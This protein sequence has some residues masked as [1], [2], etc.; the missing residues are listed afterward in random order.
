MSRQSELS[1]LVNNYIADHEGRQT[2]DSF[3]EVADVGEKSVDDFLK[4]L[5]IAVI[6]QEVKELKAINTALRRME[7]GEYGMCIDCNKKIAAARLDVNPAAERC[8]DCQN[9]Y[10]KEHG[11]NELNPSL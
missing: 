2:I 8:V 9:R 6:T 5:D 10:E 3:V 11:T 7:N 1:E 4:D